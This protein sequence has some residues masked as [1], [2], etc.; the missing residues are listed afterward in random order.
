MRLLLQDDRGV[1]AELESARPETSDEEL[2]QRFVTDRSDLAF[3]ELVTRYGPLVMGVCRRVSGNEQD[4]EDAFQATFLVL[5]RKGATLRHAGSLPAWLHKTSYRIALRARASSSRRREQP[6]DVESMIAK[7]TLPQIA[8]DH[9][10]SALDE[11]LN[12]LPDKYRQPLFLCCVEGLPRNE[13]ARRLGLSLGSLKGR[14][15]RGRQVL[16]RRLMLRRASLGVTLALVIGS[17]QTAQ[18]AVSSSLVAST[19]QA[20]MQYATGQAVVGYV[21][22][23]ALSLAN[24]SF[25]IMSLTTSKIVLCSLLVIGV[26]TWGASWL[27]APAIAG[28]AGIEGQ[29]PALQANAVASPELE[30]LIALVTD[31]EGDKSRRSPEAEAMIRRSPEAEAGPR[32]SPEAEAGPRRSAE[33]DERRMLEDFRPETEREAMLYRIVLQLQREVAQL[34]RAAGRTAAGNHEAGNGPVVRGDTPSPNRGAHWE[35]TKAG[36]VFKAYDKNGDMVVTLDEWLA[37]T[38]GN[39]S[40]ERRQLQTTRFHAAEPSGDGKFTPEEFIY[41]YTKG[42]FENRTEGQQPD[43]RDGEGAVKR[44]PRDG[45]SRRRGPR[46]GEGAVRRDRE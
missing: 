11:E 38:N 2:L 46:D 20:S 8:S 42:R 44:G 25:Q 3:A 1:Q 32:R 40:V 13:A 21:S 19:V 31:G 26:L 34:R 29:V 18:G 28:D 36:G 27:P 41:W 12:R 16:R 24:G 39:I 6:L 15:E 45:E 37:M 17:Q 14:L 7:E 10:Q 33:G 9:D 23:N 35:R 5:A 30:P 4:A 22:Q 43:V